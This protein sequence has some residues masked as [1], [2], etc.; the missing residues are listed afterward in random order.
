MVM[1]CIGVHHSYETHRIRTHAH[2]MASESPRQGYSSQNLPS[3][4]TTEWMGGV[5]GQVPGISENHSGAIFSRSLQS[6]IHLELCDAFLS[7]FESFEMTSVRFQM[8]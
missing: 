3:R 8:S 6:S 5:K 4:S 1:K 7:G 2:L